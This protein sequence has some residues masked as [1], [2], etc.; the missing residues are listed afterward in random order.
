[1]TA[2]HN[3][4][5]T[6]T[7]KRRRP[8][9]DGGEL[10][11]AWMEDLSRDR[12][13]AQ[14]FLSAMFDHFR[15]KIDGHWEVLSLLDQ[16]YRRAK[17]KPG[18]YQ[19]VKSRVDD[20]ILHGEADSPSVTAPTT[21]AA[22]STP[23]APKNTVSSFANVPHKA[24]PTAPGGVRRVAVGD[25]LRSRYRVIGVLGRG[26]MSTV[27]R[28]EHLIFHESMAMKVMS[29]DCGGVEAINESAAR[30][31]WCGFSGRNPR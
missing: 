11:V 12:C 18:I 1:M 5:G 8:S 20:W 9:A 6:K 23:A 26:G 19:I 17:I 14:E 22:A 21:S 30:C 16:Y 28:V 4:A 2:A 10:V 15:E 7:A 13:T 25:V 29:A 24:A 27:Y 31:G 3:I